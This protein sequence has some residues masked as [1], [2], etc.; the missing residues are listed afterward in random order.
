MVS[1]IL[2]QLFVLR[3][4]SNCSACLLSQLEDLLTEADIG[5]SYDVDPVLEE[6]CGSV[7]EALCS[8]IKPGE[9]R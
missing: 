2:F 3:Q 1:V 7:V 9:G 4:I 5:E 8:H 6:D